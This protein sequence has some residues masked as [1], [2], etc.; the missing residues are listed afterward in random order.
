MCVHT[1]VESSSVVYTFTSR[2]QDAS[3]RSEFFFHFVLHRSA[4]S[5]ADKQRQNYRRLYLHPTHTHAQSGR[6]ALLAL[7][8]LTGGLL[9]GRVVAVLPRAHLQV[10]DAGVAEVMYYILKEQKLYRQS[11][12]EHF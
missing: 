1:D 5:K 4:I 7:L 2:R 11:V 12:K 10:Q 3:S 6:R 9:L 8:H